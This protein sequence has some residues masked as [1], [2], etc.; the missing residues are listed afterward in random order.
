VEQGPPSAAPINGVS[1]KD[2]LSSLAPDVVSQALG[3]RFIAHPS[4]PTFADE[5]LHLD[6]AVIGFEGE[7]P[8]PLPRYRPSDALPSAK[9]LLTRRQNV[10]IK[11]V[12][13][14]VVIGRAGGFVAPNY[15]LYRGPND[16]LQQW[17]INPFEF[18]RRAFAT[19]A[20]PKPNTTTLSGRRIYYSHIDGDGWRNG[21]VN[22]R[23]LL[24]AMWVSP[25][26]FGSD[27]FSAGALCTLGC[28]LQAER[29]GRTRLEAVTALADSDRD[30][31]ILDPTYQ[32]GEQ[33]WTIPELEQIRAAKPGR[34]IL[35]YL[36]I[37]EAEDYRRYWGQGWQID[38]DGSRSA[39]T[40]GFIVAPNAD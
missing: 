21:S 32:A 10:G 39:Q 37:G 40:P 30:V 18:F 28:V 3:V 29:L 1:S 2:T 15:A 26:A 20:I 24:M 6:N 22:T 11:S 4:R 25:H 36:S 5:V 17:L 38:G 33:R 19:D 34:K 9:A 7:L 16:R 14:L 8:L 13:D 35:A 23:V 31:L 27:G 12:S